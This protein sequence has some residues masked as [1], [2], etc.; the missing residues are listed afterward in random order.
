MDAN[1]T[2]TKCISQNIDN[3][4]DT[5]DDTEGKTRNWREGGKKGG[6]VRSLIGTYS[7]GLMP[8]IF[9]WQAPSLLPQ[10]QVKRKMEKALRAGCSPS[11]GSPSLTISHLPDGD[12]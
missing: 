2:W 12:G 4:E 9:L 1:H 8:S 11:S 10:R 6:S 7:S 5:T 3:R